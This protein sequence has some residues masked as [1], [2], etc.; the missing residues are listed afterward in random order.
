MLSINKSVKKLV[1]NIVEK[2]FE[3]SANST[4][5]IVLYQPKAP[6]SLKK[7]NKIDNDK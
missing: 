7:L 6:T 5:C 2:E 4:T 3:I 1:K